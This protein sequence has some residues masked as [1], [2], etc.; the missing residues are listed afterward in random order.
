[1]GIQLRQLRGALT[2]STRGAVQPFVRE[3]AGNTFSEMVSARVCVE[4]S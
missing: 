1:M 2:E 3:T 4:V